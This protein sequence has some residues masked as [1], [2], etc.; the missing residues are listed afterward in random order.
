MTRKNTFILITILV[1]IFIVFY[2]NHLL[3]TKKSSATNSKSSE[4]TQIYDKDFDVNVNLPYKEISSYAAYKD[5]VYMSAADNSPSGMANKIIQYNRKTNKVETLF[6]TKFD[7]SSI[8]GLKANDN[9]VTWVD[10]DDFGDQKNIYIMNTKTREIEPITKENDKSIKNEFPVL[11]DNYLAWIY[12]DQNKNQSYVMIR[13]LKTHRNKT[14]FNLKTHTL[15]NAFLSIQDGKILFTD[16]REGKSYC[17]L[18]N[19]STHKLEE[20]QSPHKKI[21]W[22]ELLNDHQI[23]YLAFFTE[24]FADNKLVLFDTQ[25]KKAN[26]FS[27]KY[28]EVNGLRVDGSNHVFV[29]TGVSNHFQ[30]YQ[31][32]NG[33]IKKIG[34]IED[35]DIFD[36]TANNGVYLMK[37]ETKNKEEK[38]I[39]T[40]KLPE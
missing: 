16:I 25:T 37:I 29:G 14:V 20:F 34:E 6:T 19:I 12:F 39:I 27:S 11:A 36:M 23:V 30:K 9:W 32:D 1:L 7:S 10:S 35:N 17:Y 8:Q 40:S 15:D 38:L 22:G 3:Q 18:Y 21:G 13:D 31:I 2:G 5:N 28:M 33:N 26:E 4:K 24:S